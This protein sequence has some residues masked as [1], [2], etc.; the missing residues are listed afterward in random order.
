M[1]KDLEITKCFDILGN[2]YIGHL[3]YIS[4]KS[5]F[6]VPITYFYDAEEKCIL[7]YSTNGHKINAMRQHEHVSLQVEQIETIQDW[8]SIQVHGKFEEL[9]G[10]AAKKYIHKFSQGVQDTI[11]HVKS[12]KPKFIGDFSS[13]L[14]ER[15]MP[16]MYRIHITAITGKIRTSKK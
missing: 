14:Q 9:E 16:I 5:P 12:E 6:I 1:Y 10:S 7:S 13:R 15:K 3:G 4:G 11:V 8:T 2:N